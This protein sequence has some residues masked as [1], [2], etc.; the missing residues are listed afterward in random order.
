MN[1]VQNLTDKQRQRLAR[2]NLMPCWVEA[3]EECVD[4]EIEMRTLAGLSTPY[5][6]QVGGCNETAGYYFPNKYFYDADG[7]LN[8]MLPLGEYRSLGQ[9][10][11][12]LL[13][14]VRADKESGQ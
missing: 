8:A 6:I 2:H 5:R 10:I 4:S 1:I 12:R 13:I 3:E 9:A 11:E 14:V 7:E